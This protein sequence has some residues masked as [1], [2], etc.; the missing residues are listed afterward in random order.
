MPKAAAIYPFPS[1]SATTIL[2]DRVILGSLCRGGS[3]PLTLSR[4]IVA[5]HSA[6]EIVVAESPTTGRKASGKLG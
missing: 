4:R 1:A 3:S 6:E 2:L 5:P